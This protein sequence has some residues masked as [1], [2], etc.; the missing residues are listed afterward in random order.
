MRFKA[1]YYD[2]DS[3]EPRVV[4]HDDGCSLL[5]LEEGSRVSVSAKRS[6]V[7][8]V[9]RSP[10]AVKCNGILVPR[11]LAESIG[12]DDGGDAEVV[13]VPQPDSVSYIRKKMDGL[14]LSKKEI[15]A[16]VSDTNCHNLSSAELSAWLTALYIRGMTLGEIADMTSEMAASGERMEFS[17]TS[18]F[19]FHSIGGVPGN[20]ITPIIVSIVAS[21]G[22]MIPKLSSRAISSACGT[23][24]FVE[25]FC[26]IEL[27]A[28]RFKNVVETTGGSFALGGSIGI[29]PAGDTIIKVQHPLGIDPHPQ[30]LASILSKK[31]AL[32]TTHLLI[33]IP[34]GPD[35]KVPTVAEAKTFVNDFIELGERLG[36]RVECVVTSG[37]RPIGCAIG[38]KLE[39]RECIRVLEGAEGY[40]SV[41]DKACSLAGTILEM[42]GI[43][44]GIAE[45][46][47][48]LSSGKALE[49]FREIVAAQGGDP[50]ISSDDIV[51]GKYVKTVVSDRSG[52]ITEISN[53]KLVNIA[54]AAGSPGCKG[55]GVIVPIGKGH[56]VEKGDV[57]LEI[58]ADI[59][60]K[61]VN[62]FNLAEKTSPISVNGML[63][64][65]ISSEER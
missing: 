28:E 24:D 25:T 5:G 50:N 19:D 54:R 35:T 53:K 40:E 62:A 60:Q 2:V 64:E 22:L 43:P 12:L 58:Y 59:E 33:D 37:D 63:I 17:H 31:V 36:I 61:C 32:G 27:S 52:Y 45:A 57:I 13:P 20:K 11:T 42:G 48:I 44:N 6:F 1:K 65:R 39:A 55:A 34:M 23:S 18:V 47:R 21:A 10:T 29:A 14:E 51:P 15:S 9:S 7:A 30:M 3:A 56:R 46:H 38:P 26:D 4:I 49:K 16:I 41:S 8:I